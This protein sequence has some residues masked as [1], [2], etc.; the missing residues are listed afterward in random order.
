MQSLSYS[1]ASFDDLISFLA[2]EIVGQN[3]KDNQYIQ[4]SKLKIQYLSLESNNNEEIMKLQNNIEHLKARIIKNS[5]VVATSI[6]EVIR[7]L[8]TVVGFPVVYVDTGSNGFFLFL[9]FYFFVT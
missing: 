3:V 6:S 5:A 9:F 4:E 2:K 7:N 8:A 1:N